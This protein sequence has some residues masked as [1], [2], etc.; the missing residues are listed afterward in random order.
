[1]GIVTPYM[2]DV[3]V[4]CRISKYIYK[5]RRI[6]AMDFCCGHWVAGSLVVWSHNHRQF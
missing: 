1:M 6:V 4:A 3:G 5:E 2:V